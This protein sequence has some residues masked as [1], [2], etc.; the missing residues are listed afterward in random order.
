MVG[1]KARR[2]G[3][4]LKVRLRRGEANGGHWNVQIGLGAKMASSAKSITDSP[5]DGALAKDR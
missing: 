4:A 1:V 5:F 2:L 3:L